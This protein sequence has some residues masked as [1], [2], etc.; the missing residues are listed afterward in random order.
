MIIKTFF[1]VKDKN[2][3]EKD[4][5]DYEKA[6]FPQ[7]DLARYKLACHDKNYDIEDDLFL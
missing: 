6:S 1:L 2:K 7:Q 4:L 3:N 5:F